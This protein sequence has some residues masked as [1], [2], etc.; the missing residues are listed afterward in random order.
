MQPFMPKP[1][2]A[3]DTTPDYRV[4]GQL[5]DKDTRR[6]VS[7]TRSSSIGPT[8]LYYAGVTAPVISAGMALVA[9]N[10]GGLVGGHAL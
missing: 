7:E 6:L 1:V 2:A 3:N 10:D 5:R 8:A 4:S 9:R